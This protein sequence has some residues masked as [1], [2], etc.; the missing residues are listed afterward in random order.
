MTN[1]KAHASE[2]KYLA[3]H[4]DTEKRIPPLLREMRRWTA[5]MLLEPTEPGGKPPKKPVSLINDARTWRTFAEARKESAGRA[6]IG[7][8]M[9]GIPGVVGIDIDGATAHPLL[10]ALP[11]TYAELSPSGQGLRIFA[12]APPHTVV[13]E[14]LNR[15]QGVECYIGNSARYLTVTG[16]TLSGREGKLAELTDEALR[17]LQGAAGSKAAHGEIEIALP[18]PTAERVEAWQEVFHDKRLPYKRLKKELRH[19]LE[20]GDIPG[21]RSEKSFSV[22]CRLL[23]SRYTPEEIFLILISAPG[24]WEAAL[25]KR[26]QDPSRARALVWADIGRAQKIVRAADE[27]AGQQAEGWTGLELRTS[28]QDGKVR[29]ERSQQNAMRILAEHPEWRGRLAFDITSGRVLLDATPLDDAR[30]F[31][32][33]EKVSNYAMWPPYA[34]RQWWG[35]VVRA[36]SEKNPLNP[37]ESE[38]RGYQWDGEE[39]LDTWFTRYVAMSDDPLNRK[40][41][42]MW[43]LSC[44]ARWVNPGCKVD[45]VLVLQGVEGARKNTFYE[46]VAGAPDRVVAVEGMEREDKL[47]MSK[48]WICEMPEAHIFRKADRNRLKGFI[49]RPIDDFRPPYAAAPVAVKRAFVFASTSNS[50]ELFNTDMDGLRRFWPVEVR[51][52]INYEWVAKYRNQLLAEAVLCYDLGEQWWFDTTPEALQDRVAFAVEDTAIDEAIERLVV[53][54]AGKGRLQLGE[55]LLEIGST[56][57]FRPRDRDVTALLWK[58]GIR[59]SRTTTYRGWAHPSWLAGNVVGLHREDQSA[60][61]DDADDVTA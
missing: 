30:F 7:L 44:V 6:G 23:E 34:N 61:K 41:G 12:L 57:G 2:R 37:R 11:E 56:L 15:E 48:G 38:V 16:H 1:V 19:Y 54:Q 40:L 27:E 4:P 50:M 58:H 45:T 55:I 20:L 47:T 28:F 59:K 5:W 46:V 3:P 49:T 13:P 18:V 8:M 31:E 22:A 52:R 29:P 10:D 39:R 21:S 14:F 51:E 36:V 17:I 43:L 42:R 33:Q 25:D 35:D 53:K 9:Q 60:T 26:D 32:M 24:S